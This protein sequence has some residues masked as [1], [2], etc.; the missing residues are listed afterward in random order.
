VRT[1]AL[2]GDRPTPPVEVRVSSRRRK[3]VGAHW[4]GGTAVVVFPRHVRVADRQAF[5][6]D[7]VGRLVAAR[8]RV[9]PSDGELA[10]RATRLSDRYLDGRA[11]P[12]SVTWT[13]RQLRRW[14]S[15]TPADGSIRVSDRLRGVP[16]WVLDAVLVHELAHL[17]QPDH[18]PAFRA[19]VARHPRTSDATH[20]LAGYA[21]GLDGAA[22]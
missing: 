14:A 20:F 2:A 10:A 9:R 11:E 6:D 16:P 13:S 19:L 1:H 8:D 3:T 22:S 7:L 18:G 15:C 12:T 21:L 17:L 4:E 5:V